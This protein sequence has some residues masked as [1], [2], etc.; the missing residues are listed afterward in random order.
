M[1]RFAKSLCGPQTDILDKS[2]S[3]SRL[4]AV[5]YRCH[6]PSRGFESTLVEHIGRGVLSLRYF[7]C[8][9][10]GVGKRKD[11]ARVVIAATGKAHV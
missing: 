5:P 8:S 4:R 2:I 11:A 7:E 6:W 3:P 9:V 10:W 1:G